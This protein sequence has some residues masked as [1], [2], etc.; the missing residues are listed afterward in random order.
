MG[1][2]TGSRNK[3][4]LLK[5]NSAYLAVNNRSFFVFVLTSRTKGPH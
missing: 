2:I 4:D 3:G 1:D 5:R